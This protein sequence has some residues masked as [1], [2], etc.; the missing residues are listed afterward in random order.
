MSNH[1]G[2]G[3]TDAQDVDMTP[4]EALASEIARSGTREQRLALALDPETTPELLYYLANDED[5]DVRRALADNDR[6][7]R[8]ADE[9]LAQDE[10]DEVRTRLAG[11]LAEVEVTLSSSQ[12]ESI[13]KITEDILKRLA[14]DE[15]VRV[16]TV[17]ADALAPH[18]G[19]PADIILQ[20]A[21]DVELR[22]CGPVLTESP[23]LDDNDL[24]TLASTVHSQRPGALGC[25][26]ERK[27][28]GARVCE[29]IVATGQREA[30]TKLLSNQSAQI[31]EDTL[32]RLVDAAES[33]E[34]WHKPLC[35][36]P[37]LPQGAVERL[38]SYV[39]NTLLRVL[40]ERSDLDSET[41]RKL[42]QVVRDRLKA[43]R[44]GQCN[45][46]LSPPRGRGQNQ[47]VEKVKR[48][49]AEGKLGEC[50]IIQA[51]RS[52][53]RVVVPVAL[54]L[55]AKLDMAVVDK[56]LR[57]CRPKPVVALA[58]AANLS[59]ATATLLQTQIARIPPLDALGA[60]GDRSFALTEEEMRWQ[61]SFFSGEG[62]PIAA[63]VA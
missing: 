49:F 48:Q 15:A 33:I 7:P 19:A 52:G 4:E 51:I 23:L 17:L 34:T 28:L 3:I 20:L 36:R 43:E 50:E 44:E 14:V 32:D 10:D 9:L 1:A 57:S 55:R 27:N 24:V 41:A 25:I 8:Q 53:D 60:K 16:R 38:A 13:R 35:D 39:S 62:A 21:R 22:V 6:L 56:I 58:M 61:L 47:I 40:L 2:A 46:V 63:D 5:P 59:P 11:K 42:A 12:R 45:T 26:A 54:S 37:A 29:A 31:R 30:I 18:P